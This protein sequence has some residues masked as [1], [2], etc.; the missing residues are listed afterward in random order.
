MQ[1]LVTNKPK[2]LKYIHVD[3][4]MLDYKKGVYGGLN[5]RLY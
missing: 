2:C 5:E 3:M 4:C 1:I